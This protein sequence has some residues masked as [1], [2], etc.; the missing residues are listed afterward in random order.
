MFRIIIYSWYYNPKQLLL[1]PS[2]HHIYFIIN[3]YF[4]HAT[5]IYL[6]K[7]LDDHIN[8]AN[9]NSDQQKKICKL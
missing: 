5:C 9:K 7:M 6:N 3:N 1:P 4:F 8:S 2:A